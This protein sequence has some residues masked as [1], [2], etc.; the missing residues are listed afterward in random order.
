[1]TFI[2]I[3]LTTALI[4]NKLRNARELRDQQRIDDDSRAD[5]ER[6]RRHDKKEQE[7][8]AELAVVKA[9]LIELSERVASVDKKR[10]GVS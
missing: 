2:P 4:L 10:I 7:A 1:M 6:R 9:R 5:E 3:G 8:R